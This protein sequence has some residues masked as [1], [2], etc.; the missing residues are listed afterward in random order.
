MVTPLPAE[1]VF[2]SAHELRQT[3]VAASFVCH[4]L[5]HSPDPEG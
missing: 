2:L 4:V 3:V 1:S 5:S